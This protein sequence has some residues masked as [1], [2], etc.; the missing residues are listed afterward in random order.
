[1]NAVPVVKKLTHLP[2]AVDPSHG[3]GYTYL[4]QPMAL[5]AVACGADSIMVEVHPD[6]SKATSDGQ[7]TQDFAQFATMMKKLGAVAKAVGRTI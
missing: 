6:P 4:V 5:A 2:V 1:L 3:T 7:Q